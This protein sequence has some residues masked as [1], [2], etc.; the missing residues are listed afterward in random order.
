MNKVDLTKTISFDELCKWRF[1][2]ILCELWEIDKPFHDRYSGKFKTKEQLIELTQ[3]IQK[4]QSEKNRIIKELSIMMDEDYTSEVE[5][6]LK[7]HE[8]YQ[9]LI[10]MFETVRKWIETR[11]TELNAAE[12]AQLSNIMRKAY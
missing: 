11:I 4:L 9:T 1:H 12:L 3:R 10:E 5:E 6:V 7:Q 8:K 2:W